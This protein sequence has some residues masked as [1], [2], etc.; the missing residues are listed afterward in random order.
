[1]TRSDILKRYGIID[2]PQLLVRP[3]KADLWRVGINGQ[4]DPPTAIDIGGA[5]KLAKELEN[6]GE[7]VLAAHIVEAAYAARRSQV[8]GL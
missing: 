6:N 7:P 3:V 4:G 5:T 2:R 1:M 8:Q